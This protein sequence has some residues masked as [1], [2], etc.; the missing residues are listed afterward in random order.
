MKTILIITDN[1]P[2]QING[3]VTTFTNLERLAA[4]AGYRVVYLD[5]RQFPHVDAPG[6]AEVKLSWPRQLGAKIL[7]IS[8]DHVHIATEGPLGFFARL[9]L[10]RQGWRYNTS[11]HTK[12]ADILR[13]IYGVPRWLSWAYLRWFHRHSGVVLT[14]TPTMVQEL[15]EHGFQ[16][17]IR[18]WTRGVDREHL[19][20]SRRWR[21]DRRRPRLL[22]VGRLSPEKN[23]EDVCRLADRYRVT[24]VGDGPERARL[25]H[26]Y[27][28]VK[29]T[30]YQHGSDL[31][32]HY[33]RADVF[34]FPSRS[35]TFGIVMIEAMSQGTPVAAYDVAGP[36]D[37]VEPETGVL[38]PD[39]AACVEQCL[40]LDRSRVRQHSMRWT[41]ENCWNIFKENLIEARA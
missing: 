19:R 3:V 26:K 17:E 7:E 11:Y 2:D 29:F 24:I 8:P 13:A 23:V 34:V 40:K 22:Y 6:Y 33:A 25:E 1:L 18:S 4:G 35:D 32:D 9:W 16:G 20:A 10:D 39:L 37:V 28:S 27:P 31:A 36:R 21:R 15:Q 30:G 12:F 14:T 38:G 41:W 5:P